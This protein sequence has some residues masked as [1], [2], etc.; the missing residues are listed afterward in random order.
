MSSDEKKPKEAELSD[1]D[2]TAQLAERNK[3]KMTAYVEELDALSKKHGFQYAIAPCSHC[4]GRGQVLT[5]V[6]IQK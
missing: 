2:L 4:G 6:P 3:N 5:I 1:E